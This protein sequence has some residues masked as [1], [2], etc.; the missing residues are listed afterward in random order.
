MYR[1]LLTGDVLTQ[2]NKQVY[3]VIMSINKV[4]NYSISSYPGLPN[5]YQLL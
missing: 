1:F 5:H 4:L 2:I 3:F